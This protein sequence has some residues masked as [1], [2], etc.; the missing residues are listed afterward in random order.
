[1]GLPGRWRL[2]VNEKV[3]PF[4]AQARGMVWLVAGGSISGSTGPCLLR[5]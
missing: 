5:G 2:G 3:G 1:M 4:A